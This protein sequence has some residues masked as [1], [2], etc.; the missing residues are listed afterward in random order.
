MMEGQKDESSEDRP[1]QVGYHI[2]GIEIPTGTG[3]SL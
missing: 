2:D 3:N 1:N